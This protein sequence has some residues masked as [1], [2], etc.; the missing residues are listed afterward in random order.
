MPFPLCVSPVRCKAYQSWPIL[1]VVQAGRLAGRSWDLCARPCPGC[2]GRQTG[3]SVDA[4][5]RTENELWFW[6]HPYFPNV[7]KSSNI[8]LLTLRSPGMCKHWDLP[9]HFPAPCWEV[10]C[11]LLCLRAHAHALLHTPHD[12]PCLTSLG[13]SHCLAASCSSFGTLYQVWWS[14]SLFLLS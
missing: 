11:A 4:P 6:L 14:P 12:I 2:Q 10:A 7:V 13:Q 9:F 1:A 5:D 8:S 3:W